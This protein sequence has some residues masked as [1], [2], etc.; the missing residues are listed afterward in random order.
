MTYHSEIAKEYLRN[1]FHSGALDITGTYEAV[2]GFVQIFA[3]EVD[4]MIAISQC[5]FLTR[6]EVRQLMAIAKPTD[7]TV[8]H[9]KAWLDRTHRR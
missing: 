5:T 7:V 4:A 9:L 3:G 6:Q 8:R 1:A 2:Q